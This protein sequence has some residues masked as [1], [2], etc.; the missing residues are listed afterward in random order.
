M[1]VVGIP[2]KK[3]KRLIGQDLS[4]E[5]LVGCCQELGCDVEDMTELNRIKCASCGNIIEFPH[6]ETLPKSCDICQSEFQTEGMEYTAIAPTEVIR[7]D[8]LADRPDNFDAAGISRSI[9]GYLDIEK[10]LV[11]YNILQSK[12]TVTVDSSMKDPASY[13][14][15]IVCAIIKNVNFND[16]SLKNIMKLQE[17]LHWALGR[18]RKYASIGVY[19]LDKIQSTDIQY[20]PVG[21]EELKFAPLGS[22][23]LDEKDMM[24]PGE[25]LEKHP[26]GVD[27]AH[28]LKDLKKYPL[29]IDSKG[30]V[31]SMP[32]IINSE[33]TRVTMDSKNLFIDV[34]GL[35]EIS[36]NKA[37]N[38]IVTSVI[39]WDPQCSIHSVTVKYPDRDITTPNLSHD[40]FTLD[41]N[42][43]RN[44]IGV[45]LTDDEIMDCLRRMRYGVEKKDSKCNVKIPCYRTDILHE[46]DLIE[47]VA[48][49]YGYK[50]IEPKI[51]ESFTIGNSIPKQEKKQALRNLLTGLGFFEVLNIMLTSEKRSYETLSMP[52]PD[53]TVIIDNPISSDQ[54]IIRTELTSG[55]METLAINTRH[56]LPQKIFEIG[57]IVFHDPK[58]ETGTRIEVSLAISKIGSRMGFADIK[59]ILSSL[60]RETGVPWD[61][62]AKELPIYLNGR[63]GKILIK[64]KEAGHIGEIN[65]EILERYHIFNP[66]VTLELNLSASGLI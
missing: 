54:T 58:G 27:Y 6:T 39:E 51:I 9:R 49:A 66:V 38:I 21:K 43:S 24:T 44:L 3:L 46:Y 2:V 37:L 34:T 13:R 16:D 25:I 45:D 50:N 48:I 20:R 1:P 57:D 5:N 33:D 17:N 40:N 52:V 8:L 31:L 30:I 19:D 62:E 47:D 32:P 7:L 42:N 15:Y 10:D 53:N 56:E 18:D 64:N 29:L 60:M 35:N 55:L 63:S 61:I 22:P 36:I 11:T 14:P 41:F 23:G 59:S 12:Y 4:N 65:P 28:L 26:K